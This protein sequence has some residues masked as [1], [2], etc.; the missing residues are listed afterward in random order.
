MQ[1]FKTLTTN[2]YIRG[3]KM[4]EW[5]PFNKNYGNAIIGN[6]LSVMKLPISITQISLSITLQIGTMINFVPDI[7]TNT[8]TDHRHSGVMANLRGCPDE[9]GK[10]GWLFKKHF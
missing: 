5:Q 1:W 3:V 6:T 10:H 2:E 9:N 4:L 7:I 8:A